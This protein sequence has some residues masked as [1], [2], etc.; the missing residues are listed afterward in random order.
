MNDRDTT[1]S[2]V[3]LSSQA[4]A[5]GV[6]A[7]ASANQRALDYWKSLWEISSRPY[8]STAIETCVRENFDRANQI[9]G[10]TINELQASGKNFT[11][12]AQ[13]VAEH[14]AKVQDSG[15]N[16]F[17]GLMNAGISNMNYVKDTTAQQFED[18]TKRLDEIQSR[19]TASVS[20]N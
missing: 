14:N 10:L 8:T 19:A 20:N 16:A 18:L 7:F 4:Y 15:A 17:R 5:L 6:G 1:A 12:F 13:K 3:E 9:V 11:D 2:Y